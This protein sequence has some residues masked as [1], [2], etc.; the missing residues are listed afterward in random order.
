MELLKIRININGHGFMPQEFLS[1]FSI[2]YTV[3]LTDFRGL[4]LS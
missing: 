3:E 1:D 2:Y 4:Y